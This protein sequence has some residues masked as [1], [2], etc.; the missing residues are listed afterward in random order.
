MARSADILTTHQ[1]AE[2][3]GVNPVTVAR[4]AKAGRLP[5]FRTAG[6]HRRIRK[7]DLDRFLEDC[8]FFESASAPIEVTE[9]KVL[10]AVANQDLA[11]LIARSA[12][13]QS[14][15]AEVSSANDA[16]TA[17]LILGRDRPTVLFLDLKLPGVDGLELCRRLRRDTNFRGLRIVALAA[18]GQDESEIL[19]AGASECLTQ[20]IGPPDIRDVLARVP[21]GKSPLS[22]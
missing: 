4:W 12:A 8:G 19:T 16:F 21:A 10:V 20:P 14:G 1:V 13:E 2:K 17:G 5:A 9:S 6:G 3:L 11:T 18:D 15:V 7:A 22:G